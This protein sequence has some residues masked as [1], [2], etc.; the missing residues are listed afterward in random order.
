ML[1]QE[2]AGAILATFFESTV[3]LGAAEPCAVGIGLLCRLFP[4]AALLESFQVDHVCHVRLHYTA[5]RRHDNS[6]AVKMS[7]YPTK[8]NWLVIRNPRVAVPVASKNA[9]RSAK[10]E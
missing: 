1:V 8:A 2:I 4:L 5:T 10:T 6:S 7:L 3:G 9:F